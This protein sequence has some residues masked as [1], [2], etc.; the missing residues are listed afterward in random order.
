MS[1]QEVDSAAELED[2]ISD[3]NAVVV[4]S[5]EQCPACNDMS[6]WLNQQFLPKH[7]GP[8][9]K[10]VVAKLEKIGRNVV[11]DF[12]LRTMPTTVLFNQG[13]EVYRVTGFN[14]PAPVERAIETHLLQPA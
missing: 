1:F 3:G 9:L 10:V 2:V 8:T 12:N 14:G 11:S 6:R 4:F 7:D 13:D 5:K